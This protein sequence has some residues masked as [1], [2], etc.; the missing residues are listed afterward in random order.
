[1]PKLFFIEPLIGKITISCLDI[2][3][4]QTLCSEKF[5]SCRFHPIDLAAPPPT[6]GRTNA[7]RRWWK[8]FKLG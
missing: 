3:A 1:M 4:E 6:R 5:Y 7:C 8:P 2:Y